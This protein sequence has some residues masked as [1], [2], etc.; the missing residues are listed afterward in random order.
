M[1]KY[2]VILFACF[3]LVFASGLNLHAH[4][5]GKKQTSFSL[6]SG[7]GSCCCKKMAKDDCCEDEITTLKIS[8]SH[9]Q[10]ANLELVEIHA[11][12]PILLPNRDISLLFAEN[13]AVSSFYYR[14]PPPDKLPL[15]IKNCLFTI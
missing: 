10:A 11:A 3:Y 2:L 14:P 6:F 7:K 1:R 15:F 5:C 12:L 8:D 13:C 4:F 9:Q